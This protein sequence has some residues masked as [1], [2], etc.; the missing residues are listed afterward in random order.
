MPDDVPTV[1]YYQGQP[2]EQ[3]T[4][5]ELIEAVKVLGANLNAAFERERRTHDLY[6]GLMTNRVT[7]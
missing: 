3:L 2:I 1:T 4:R 7:R 5:E 6:R